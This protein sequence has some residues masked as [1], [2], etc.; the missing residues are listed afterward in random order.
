[1]LDARHDA[2]RLVHGESDGLPG[3]IADRYGDTIVVQLLSA[4]AE[5]VARRDRRRAGRGDGAQRP[6]SS[7]PT[8][9]CAQLEGLAPRTGV[10]RG[11]RRTVR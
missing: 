10:L 2:C 1:M 6:W 7:A 9:R 4:G 11:A 8:P 5:R 3:V